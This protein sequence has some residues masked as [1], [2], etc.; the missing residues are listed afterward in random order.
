MTALLEVDG[1]TKGFGS[2]VL[3]DISFALEA[4]SLTAFLGASGSG[5]T[6]LLRLIAG[7]E[8]PD[9]GEIRL[10]GALIAS[11]RLSVRPERRG[12]GYVA[13][14]G[15][16]FPHLSVADNITFGL[17]RA[18]RRARTGVV[19]L[20]E[21]VGLPTGFADRAPQQLSG[22][23]QQ[24]VALARALA[25]APALVL[26]D[27]PFSAL[28]AGLR[29]QT[30]A[31]VAAALAAAGATAIL[32]T[33][34]QAEA[35][36]MGARVGVLQAGTLKQ[37]SP[38]HTLYRAPAD[39]ALA[40]FVG[41]AVALP[42][43]AQRGMAACELGPVRLAGTVADGPVELM[44]RPEQIRIA[45]NSSAGGVKARLGQVTFYGHDATVQLH[46]TQAPDALVT[47]RAFSDSLP[48]AGSDV[49]VHV[50]GDVIAYP[51]PSH[52]ATRT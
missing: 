20:L 27:E 6:T 31:A 25:P 50:A 15:A 51:A 36:S 12:I 37:L 33:H 2:P 38:P 3:R 17:P 30:R 46:L 21:M 47:A 19:R 23:E 28:D 32:V 43:I 45:R 39:A 4:G 1:L 9:A 22:G 49:W 11:P 16:L 5:K 34:D 48:P 13:Q 18:A 8:Q 52:P 26:L 40:R 42:A 35:L 24:R 7:F 10:G 14:E 41:D 44:I 29:A